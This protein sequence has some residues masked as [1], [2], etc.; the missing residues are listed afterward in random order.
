MQ[1][2]DKDMIIEKQNNE[3]TA[4]RNENA[5][6]KDALAELQQQMN[7]MKKQIFGRKSEKS[8]ILMN[9]GKQLS[10][11]SQTDSE[12]EKVSDKEETINPN[13]SQSD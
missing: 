7:W 5:V 1:L 2:N 11:F 12:K 8:C 10:M 13:Y 4:L 3:L 9:D 6:L